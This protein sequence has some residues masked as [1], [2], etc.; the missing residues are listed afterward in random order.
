MDNFWY[1]KL[2]II[3]KFQKKIKNQLKNKIMLHSLE[4]DPGRKRR[5]K[6]TLKRIGI[7]L[8]IGIII[9]GVLYYLDKQSTTTPQE[10]MKYKVNIQRSWSIEI[11]NEN[12]L[13][14]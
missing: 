13:L 9:L 11:Y 4:Y 12:L 3:L 1:T 7:I 5:A 6:E 14:L 8:L 2:S 10:K